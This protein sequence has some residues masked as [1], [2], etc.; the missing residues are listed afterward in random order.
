MIAS[1]R[2]VWLVCVIA[3]RVSKRQTVLVFGETVGRALNGINPLFYGYFAAGAVQHDE[4][5]MAIAVIGL[6]CATGLNSAL[7]MI[8]TSARIKQQEY[9][10]FEFSRRVATM[11]ASI[12]TLDHHEDPE[13]LDKLQAFRDWSGTVGETVNA[14]LGVINTVASSAVTL[15]VAV[16]ADWRLLILVVL[17]I[18]R[19]VIAPWT[20][21]WDK[22][23]EEEGSPHRRLSNRLVDMTRNV[24]A[25]AEAR[26]F[27]LRTEV[28]ARVRGSS[29]SW[30]RPDIRRNGKY[31]VLD[32]ANG[33]LYF[34]TAAAII[35]WIL[36]DAIHGTVSVS[37]LTISIT[38]LGALQSVSAN[39]VGAA[40]WLGQS[41]RS[42]VRFV[43]LQDYSAEVHTRHT[44]NARPPLRLRSGIRLQD[45]GYRYNG[46]ETDSLSGIDVDLPAGSV[47]ALV[48]EN[49]AGKST[50]VKLLTG[51][52]QPTRGR[53]LID[54]V[55]LADIDLTAWRARCSGAFQDHA[56]FEFIARESI[57][58]GDVPHVDDESSVRRALHNAAAT[59]VLT[60]LPDELDTQLGPGWP[61]GVDLSGGQW[62]RLALAR[63]MMRT[64]PLMLALDEPTSALDAATE[65]AL[66][67]RYAA[68]AQEAG[69]RGA[70]TLLVTHRFSTVA[71]ADSVLVLVNGR[72]VE[73]GTHHELMAAGGTYA[74]LYELQAKGYR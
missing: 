39:V 15:I 65:H 51:M 60:A 2:A 21:R 50:M 24:D 10:G 32:L 30:Q 34:G 29:Q 68:T 53:V 12:E 17:G 38:C 11:M 36:H 72:I 13:V 69:H 7:Q 18:P 8:G 9:V 5:H 55:D 64:E 70:V 49:G 48:G 63:G 59:D 73:S 14:F 71:A 45:L 74:E 27:N 25:G 43:W 42:A 1:I 66:F 28:L 56:N 61:G 44:G 54:G 62:Q 3:F 22:A 23:A 33:L 58:I 46:A 35:G 31:T 40:R 41:V 6:L 37:A 20:A 52:Y 57:G 4:A 67:D 26:V 47:V 19:L 16:T